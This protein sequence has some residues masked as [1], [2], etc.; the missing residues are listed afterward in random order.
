MPMMGPTPKVQTAVNVA[1]FFADRILGGTA[2]EAGE[3]RP[4]TKAEERCYDAALST[5][6]EYF[7]SD[8][9]IKTPIYGITIERPPQDPPPPANKP[10][11]QPVGP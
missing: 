8:D 2:D 3:S 7:N 10:E 5:I 1:F 9:T 4:L 6:T 11:P